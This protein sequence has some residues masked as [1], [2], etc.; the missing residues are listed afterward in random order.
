MIGGGAIGCEF[1]SLL[2]DLGSQVTVIEALDSLLTGC[3]PD[4]IAVVNRSFRK[5]GIEVVTGAQVQGHAPQARRHGHGGPLWPAVARSRWPW[6]SSRWAGGPAPRG[7]CR[8]ARRWCL[9]QRGY[10]VANAYQQTHE[11]NVWA[12]GDLVAGTPQL[13]HVGFAEAIVVIKS[14]LGEPV[15]PVD[16]SRVPWAIYCHPEVAFAG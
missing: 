13:A 11:R 9:D 5:R 3:D 14:I 15:I 2:S 12:V 10:V 1:A 8:R 6:W 7:S 4:L 16:Y